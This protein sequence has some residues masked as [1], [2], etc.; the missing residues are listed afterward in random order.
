MGGCVSQWYSRVTLSQVIL[1]TIVLDVGVNFGT[2]VESR[3]NMIPFQ[4]YSGTYLS[5]AICIEI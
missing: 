1:Y 3:L 4:W 5:N 2:V